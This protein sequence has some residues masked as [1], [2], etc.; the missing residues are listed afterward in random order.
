[1]ANIKKKKKKIFFAKKSCT[2][3]FITKNF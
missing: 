2:K 3:L 1:M